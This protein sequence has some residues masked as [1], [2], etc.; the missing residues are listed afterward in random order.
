ML[1][2]LH[3][4]KNSDVYKENSLLWESQHGKKERKEIERLHFSVSSE[5]FTV[6]S[7]FWVFKNYGDDLCLI[8]WIFIRIF[9][10]RFY[11]SYYKSLFKKFSENLFPFTFHIL[12]HNGKTSL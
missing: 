10:L 3:F 7:E 9:K 5:L 6:R 8:L 11:C 1:C 2:T 4:A 12:G